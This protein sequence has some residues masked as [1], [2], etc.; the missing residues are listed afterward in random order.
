MTHGEIEAI[1]RAVCEKLGLDPEARA[2]QA[3]YDPRGY[4]ISFMVRWQVVARQV[5]EHLA[6]QEA[7]A[8]VRGEK[9]VGG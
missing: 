4:S 7:I 6:M 9:G 8:E 2:A 5:R 1:A 3:E